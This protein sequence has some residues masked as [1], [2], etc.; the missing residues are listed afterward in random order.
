MPGLVTRRGAAR[1]TSPDAHY[2]HRAL[3]SL[4]A[5]FAFG[6]LPALAANAGSVARATPRPYPKMRRANTWDSCL[7]KAGIG[8]CSTSVRNFRA[9]AG[10]TRHATGKRGSFSARRHLPS[11]PVGRVEQ[12]GQHHNL[13]TALPQA[14]PPPKPH[15][16]TVLPGPTRPARQASSRASGI[17]PL[18]VLP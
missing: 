4:D 11:R 13:H 2:G 16:T 14:S 1:T 9:A 5:S 12:V 6:I 7:V 18:E 17:D 3:R 15:T 10:G 8:G